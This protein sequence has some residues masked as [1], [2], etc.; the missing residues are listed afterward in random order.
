MWWK[1]ELIGLDH[2]EIGAL[3]LEKWQFPEL[4]IEPVREHHAGESPGKVNR[5][6]L[7]LVRIMDSLT[8]HIGFTTD[9]EPAPLP[10]YGSDLK[11]LGMD[12]ETLALTKASLESSREEIQAMFAAMR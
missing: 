9:Q 6:D 12:K 3:L 8:C 2:G 1:R 7:A 4:I 10:I 5:M 11:V